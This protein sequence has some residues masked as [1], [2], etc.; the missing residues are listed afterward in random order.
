MESTVCGIINGEAQVLRT[1]AP[2]LTARYLVG[3]TRAMPQYKPYNRGSINTPI[4]CSSCGE[5]FVRSHGPQ[6]RCDACRT[7]TCDTCGKRYIPPQGRAQSR[8]CSASCKGSHPDNIKRLHEQRGVK[9]RTYHLRKRDRWGN[10]ADRDWRTAVFERDD[11]TCQACGVRGGRLQAHHIKPY[12]EH[13]DLRHELSN[14]QTLC[15]ECHKKTDTYGWS[16]YW[17]GRK[18]T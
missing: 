4:A 18:R 14:G 2:P 7:M 16:K 8:F 9:T 12:R 1:P 3:G 15:V 10:A 5:L 6:K 17:Y 13:T 11:Y